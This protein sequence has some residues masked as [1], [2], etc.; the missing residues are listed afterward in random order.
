MHYVQVL[1]QARLKQQHYLQEAEHES[2]VQEAKQKVTNRSLR[3]MVA[4]K[5]VDMGER[6]AQQP[7]KA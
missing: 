3:Q 1:E 5:L 2:M 7:Q 6:L 4:Q